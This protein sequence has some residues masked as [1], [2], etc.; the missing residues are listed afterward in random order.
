MCPVMSSMPAR[1]LR[2][3]TRARQEAWSR[4]SAGGRPSGRPDRSSRG[5]FPAPDGPSEVRQAWWRTATHVNRAN[6]RQCHAG[7]SDILCLGPVGSLA[8]E[9]PAEDDG[10]SGF[11]LEPL[12]W[13]PFP[14]FGRIV[15]GEVTSGSHGAAQLRVQGL[16]LVRGV[17]DPAHAFREGEAGNDVVPVAP[18][19]QRDRRVSLSPVAGL[20]PLQRLIVG[21]C[22]SRPPYGGGWPRVFEIRPSRVTPDRRVGAGSSV[23][24]PGGS[25]HQ[26][27]FTCTPT[28][29]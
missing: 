16:D 2:N 14:F 20:E 6:A 25:P 23:N 17:N 3:G 8:D 19:A 12:A 26:S 4:K 24:R 7:L 29:A 10:E 18:P 5:R 22:E 11:G 21:V 9:P 27:A 1:S 13:R 15:I 28:P